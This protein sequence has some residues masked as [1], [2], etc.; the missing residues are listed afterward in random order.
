MPK[1]ITRSKCK[2]WLRL[3]KST[4]TCNV[5][6]I[7]CS[8]PLFCLIKPVVYINVITIIKNVSCYLWYWIFVVLLH[9]R[10]KPN[11]C[12]YWLTILKRSSKTHSP[13]WVKSILHDAKKV[14]H[15]FHRWSNWL[16]H[17]CMEEIMLPLSTRN[18]IFTEQASSATTICK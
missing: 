12:L 1:F 15:L 10:Y 13:V 18:R 4:T 9:M 17:L 7:L 2:C 5:L 14:I 8:V 11:I 3:Q 6:A 16:Y